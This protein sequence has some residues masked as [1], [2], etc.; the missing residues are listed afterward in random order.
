MHQKNRRQSVKIHFISID[1][2][3]RIEVRPSRD[4]RPQPADP[5]TSKLILLRNVRGSSGPLQTAF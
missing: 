4:L 3:G 1:T 5:L 2:L